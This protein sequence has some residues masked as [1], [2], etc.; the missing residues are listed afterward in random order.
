MADQEKKR[1]T[2]ALRNFS[3]STGTLTNLLDK[4][5]PSAVVMPEVN[6]HW[7]KVTECWDKLQSAHDAFLEE[8][9]IVD[10][11]TNKDGFP[12]LDASTVTYNGLLTKYTKFCSDAKTVEKGDVEKAEVDKRKAEE[13]ESKRIEAERL[14]TERENIDREKKEKFEEEKKE[15]ESA[16]DTFKRMNASIKETLKDASESD[17]RSQLE[18]C[19]EEF[20]RLKEKFI[21]L[22]VSID[23]NDQETFKEL[24]LESAEK[25]F[26][27]TEKWLLPEV[28]NTPKTS[29]GMSSSS[30]TTTS[31]STKTETVHLPTFQGDPTAS[32]FHRFPAWKEKWES[33]IEEY[34]QKYHTTLLEKHLDETAR[35]KYVGWENNYAESMKRLTLFYGDKIKIVQYAMKEVKLAHPI[36]E[37][38]YHSLL[39]YSATLESNF[40]RLKSMKIE[41]EMSNT[42]TMSE[43][44]RKFP[45]PVC[46]KWNEFLSGQDEN[47]KLKPFET[48]VEWLVKQREMWERM[49]TVLPPSARSSRSHYSDN[50]RDDFPSKKCFVCNKEGH[51]K[52]DCPESSSS[53]KPPKTRRKPEVKKFWCALHKGD[54]T[55]NC[56]TNSCQ[57]LQRI[58]AVKRIELLKENGDCFHCCGDHKPDSCTKKDRKCGGEK[59]KKGCSKDHKVHELFCKN[60]ALQS[61]MSTLPLQR[62]KMEL[63]CR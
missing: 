22:S 62:G 40:N 28:K 8:T 20:S 57:A 14:Q 16:I 30:T 42:S 18:R 50:D 58:D 39:S 49:A 41:S 61:S 54:P 4:N 52:R 17:K 13:A 24:Y 2:I 5:Q 1:R 47:I 10:L 31:K 7:E 60:C 21:K 6:K 35:S 59:G 11:E 51:M 32:P 37:G 3:R 36:S 53:Q 33:L 12:Y 56:F 23:D 46:E 15:F 43:I 29:G 9:D 63:C 34:D 44:L 26:T 55:R 48:F 19:T 38:D 25:P 27:E 45:R